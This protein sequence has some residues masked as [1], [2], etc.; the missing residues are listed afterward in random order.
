[1]PKRILLATDGSELAMKAADTALQLA[2]LYQA[3]VEI[4]HVIP[5]VQ[6]YWPGA[7]G[8]PGFESNEH[9]PVMEEAREMLERVGRQFAAAGIDYHTA[10]KFGDPANEICSLAEEEASELI[11]MGNNN[12]KPMTRV[13]LFLP[14]SASKKVVAHAPCPVMVIR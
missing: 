8:V 14:D 12:L 13:D 1:M 10:V 3:Q 4:I 9:N 6:G 7:Y 5:F 11:V 2:K